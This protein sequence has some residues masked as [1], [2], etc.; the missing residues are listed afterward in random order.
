MSALYQLKGRV[1]R[2]AQQAHA[3]FITTGT[4]LSVEAQSRLDYLKVL[5]LP[6]FWCMHILNVPLHNGAGYFL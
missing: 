6:M 4:H 1:G 3:Y 5:T 2:S